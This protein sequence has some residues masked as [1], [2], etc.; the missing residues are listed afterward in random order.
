VI[1][2]AERV[3]YFF[4]SDSLLYIIVDWF[5]ELKPHFGNIVMYLEHVLVI[6]HGGVV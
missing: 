1:L 6:V 2:L 4:R 3:T 5:G